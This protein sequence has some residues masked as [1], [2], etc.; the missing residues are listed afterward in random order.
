MYT[1]TYLLRLF[2]LAVRFRRYGA[3][4]ALASIE[5]VPRNLVWLLRL[6]TFYIP[7]KFGLPDSPGERLATAFAAM[8]PSYIKLGQT[9]ATRPDVV[10]AEI[11]RGLT[12]L[13]DRLPPFD[14]ALAKATIESELGDELGEF[15]SH[16]D[17][18][19]IAAASIAQVHKATTSDGQV[20]AVKILRPGIKRRFARD[21]ALFTWIATKAERHST[22][23]KRLRPMAVVKTVADSVAREM[24]L[25]LE[26]AAASELAEN[27]QGF[28]GYRIPTLYWSHTTE[29]LLTSEWIEGIKLTDMKAVKAAGHDM[30]QLA[31]TIVQAFLTQ[32]MHHGF[33]HADLH[34]GNFLIEKDSTIVAVDFG[35]M[36]RLSIKERRFLAEILHGFLVRDYIRVAEVHFDAGYVPKDQSLAEFAQALRAIAE[37]ILD[38]PIEEMLAG[39]LLTQLFATTERFAMQTQPQLIML[40]RSMVMSEGLALHLDP[41][42]NMFEIS[43]PVLE[44]WARENLSPEIMLAD[45]LRKIPSLLVRLPDALERILAEKHEVSAPIP[46]KKGFWQTMLPGLGLAF[47]IIFIFA[48]LEPLLP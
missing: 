10:G 7:H 48:S 23:A 37:P 17:E 9:L 42:A 40:Q 35:I 1:I 46:V 5:L 12:T 36:G 18:V 3:L 30:G 44:G 25:R 27:M 47:I 6:L 22:K 20:V 38:L 14:F 39:T 41:T 16:I 32:A 11:A 8:G 26:A 13:Q 29:R 31:R 28:E 21:L 33:F 2:G 24:D 45:A 15:F 34:Q 43:R 19:P 4:R